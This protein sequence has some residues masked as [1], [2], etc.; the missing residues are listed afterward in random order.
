M[1]LS[2]VYPH[3]TFPNGYMTMD[4]KTALDLALEAAEGPAEMLR[5]HAS[6]SVLEAAREAMTP[7]VLEAARQAMSPTVL[8]AARE[9]LSPSV[10]EMAREALSPSML[11]AAREALSPSVLEDAA[12]FS[13]LANDMREQFEPAQA[14]LERAR[15]ALGAT[16]QEFAHTFGALHQ[17]LL[18]AEG[19]S[20]LTSLRDSAE[21][22]QHPLRLQD[23]QKRAALSSAPADARADQTAAA[24]VEQ[25]RQRTAPS[26]SASTP[27][28]TGAAA[29]PVKA[30]IDIG[31][32]IKAAR[33]ERGLTQ[34]QLAE[35]AGVGR[36]FL[37]ELEN[38]K[39]TLEFDKVLD[40]ARAA[41][42]ELMA[43]APS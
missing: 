22:V 1:I 11:E 24:K 27:A 9:A 4:T 12:R 2:D 30:A 6:A 21:A 29:Q 36:R 14:A 32:L 41:G 39:A 40:V 3:T 42:V 34:Q 19:L 26:A 5:R 8:E 13:T 10:L 15:A 23:L 33:E 38:G 16:G 37:S 20:A 43:R 7:S 31:R 28:P 18:D 35:A 17:R 25:A